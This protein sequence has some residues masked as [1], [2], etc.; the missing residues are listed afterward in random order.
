MSS[1]IRLIC[2]EYILGLAALVIVLSAS[3]PSNAQRALAYPTVPVAQ[4]FPVVVG[5]QQ[6][7]LQTQQMLQLA[8]S[9]TSFA[10]SGGG[11]GGFGGGFGGGLG[12]FGGGGLGG[13]G[14]FNG[15]FG[16]GLGGFGGLGTG[17]GGFGSG[18][19]GFNGLGGGG[20]GGGGFGG[21]AGKGLGGFNGRNGL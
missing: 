15:G 14:G 7:A 18:L 12:G 1:L 9:P 5:F 20:F 6:S 21:F 10:L 17:V 4:P 13:F 16:G 8:G 19:G 11:F 2:L 3:R